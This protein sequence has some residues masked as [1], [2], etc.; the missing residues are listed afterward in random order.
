[1]LTDPINNGLAFNHHLWI[2]NNIRDIP[3]FLT[4]CPPS[5]LSHNN[6]PM[7]YRK[8]ASGNSHENSSGKRHEISFD[9]ASLTSTFDLIQG[10][11]LHFSRAA[12]E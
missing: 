12:C 8:S 2:Q 9:N 1:M 7:S 11:L 10:Y 3:V 5:A 4:G 6:W